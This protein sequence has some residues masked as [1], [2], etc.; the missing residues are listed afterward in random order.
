MAWQSIPKHLLI[1]LF[2]FQSAVRSSRRGA[3]HIKNIFEANPHLSNLNANLL[4]RSLDLFKNQGFTT[5]SYLRII[6][7]YPKILTTPEPLLCKNLELW[8]ASQFGERY[9]QILVTEHPQ[10]LDINVD[11]IYEEQKILERLM[12]LK[13][14]VQTKKNVWRLLLNS[15]NL[16]GDRQVEVEEKRSFFENVMKVEHTEVVKTTA[17]SHTLQKIKLR[18]EFLVRLGM[19]KPRN[20]KSDPTLK[21]RNPS[22][23]QILDT[24]DKRFATKIALVSMEEFEVFQE[25]FEQQ[26]SQS[27]TWN[28]SDD[29]DNEDDD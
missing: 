17:F 12:Y 16:I 23:Y 1:Q 2:F 4:E 21:S 3:D 22:L 18:H 20:P 14:Y 13:D 19:Y 6:S 29:T 27:R 7:K 9:V 11:S 10:L 25:L 5:E 24:S 26:D 28:N 8:R 15:P